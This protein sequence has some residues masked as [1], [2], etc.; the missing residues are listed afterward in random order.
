MTGEN[1]A[2]LVSAGLFLWV[3]SETAFVFGRLVPHFAQALALA[4]LF[5]RDLAERFLATAN[6]NDWRSLHRGTRGREP[7]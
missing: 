4:G 7:W 2:R 3:Q 5:T 6:I 1:Q